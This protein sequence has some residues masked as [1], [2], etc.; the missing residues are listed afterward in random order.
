MPRSS[1]I[2]CV[3]FYFVGRNTLKPVLSLVPSHSRAGNEANQYC[4][5][6]DVVSHFSTYSPASSSVLTPSLLPYL[7]SQECFNSPYRCEYFKEYAEPVPTETGQP[8]PGA[9]ESCRALSQVAREHGVF[10]VGGTRT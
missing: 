7:V 4:N 10:L 9:G 6:L 2:T 1:A 5:L 3:G 8:G